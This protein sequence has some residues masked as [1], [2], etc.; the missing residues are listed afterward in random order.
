MQKLTFAFPKHSTISKPT[1]IHR[2]EGR[3]QMI[4]KNIFCSFPRQ[5][6][7]HREILSFKHTPKRHLY[8]LGEKNIY[9]TA[10]ISWV[11]NGILSFDRLTGKVKKMI[12]TSDRHNES[13]H[14]SLSG[15]ILSSLKGCFT[16][17]IWETVKILWIWREA[18]SLRVI[19]PS[20]LIPFQR[21]LH[22]RKPCLW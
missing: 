11:S 17:H 4:K 6:W 13:T 19:V 14:G 18:T 12:M 3:Q 15:N 7:Q 8:P 1:G 2:K 21:L 9:R 20:W 16:S 5:R 10:N 22:Y